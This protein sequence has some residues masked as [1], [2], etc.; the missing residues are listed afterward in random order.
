MNNQIEV[1]SLVFCY[2]TEGCRGRCEGLRAVTELEVRDGTIYYKVTSSD[3]SMY[4]GDYWYTADRLQLAQRPPVGT[5]TKFKIGDRVHCFGTYHIYCSTGIIEH[6][7]WFEGKPDYYVTPTATPWYGYNDNSLQ[8]A[9][10][11]VRAV[12]EL[13]S[14][15]F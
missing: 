8:L 3:D 15:V 7:V 14:L 9:I 2:R 10:E 13:E 11:P 1:G 6:I 5:E 4:N 12:P